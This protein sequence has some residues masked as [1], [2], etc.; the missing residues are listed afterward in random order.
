M[1]TNHEENFVGLESYK[2]D[3][4]LDQDIVLLRNRAISIFGKIFP[5]IVGLPF[6][7]MD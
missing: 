5:K 3:E 6:E 7:S 2:F 1:D 4:K